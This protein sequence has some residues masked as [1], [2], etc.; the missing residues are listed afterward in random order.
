MIG[1]S[2]CNAVTKVNSLNLSGRYFTQPKSDPY[3]PT[4]RGPLSLH[5]DL[6]PI[7]RPTK[8]KRKIV[9]VHDEDLLT[10]FNYV[11]PQHSESSQSEKEASFTTPSTSFHDNH[12]VDL[13]RNVSSAS[14]NSP[15]PIS[16]GRT[17]HSK[18]PPEATRVA[19]NVE[20]NDRGTTLKER[21]GNWKRNLGIK[22]KPRIKSAPTDTVG[23]QLSFVA[24]GRASKNLPKPETQT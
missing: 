21:C 8:R 24:D 19:N 23:N 11:A 13:S 7:P 22:L 5:I 17:H 1:T 2:S 9:P 20:N 18:L 6:E 12:L 15:I 14:I 4:Y 3:R 10:G 16:P